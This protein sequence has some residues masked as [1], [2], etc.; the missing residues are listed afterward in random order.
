AGFAVTGGFL[1]R[2]GGLFVVPILFYLLATPLRIVSDVG[3]Y[4]LT[5]VLAFLTLEWL[6]FVW[7]AWRSGHPYI[8]REA[9]L[10]GLEWVPLAVAPLGGWPLNFNLLPFGL[11]S[12]F[13]LFL[14]N[15]EPRINVL[16]R[17][18]ALPAS[19][20]AVFALVLLINP[21]F[22]FDV[23]FLAMAFLHP[24]LVVSKIE[25]A[26]SI[27]DLPVFQRSPE[28]KELLERFD[29]VIK[30]RKLEGSE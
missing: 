19:L 17:K 8:I 26:P 15:K 12:F 20:V 11:L 27:E 30:Q 1:F 3:L 18:L 6:L 5:V 9:P 2:G 25:T 13:F 24:Y 4:I 14:L 21:D 10:T 22:A 16:M 29:R 23:I 7:D 28:V